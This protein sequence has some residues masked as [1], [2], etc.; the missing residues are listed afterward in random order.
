MSEPG[1]YNAEGDPPGTTRYWDGSKWIGEPVPDPTG[2][3]RLPSGVQLA[4]AGTRIGARAIDLFI[5]IVISVIVVFPTITQIIDGVDAIGP[6]ATDTQLEQV[7]T[8]ALDANA[9]RLLLA[10]AIGVAWDLAWVSAVGGTPGKLMLGLRVADPASGASPPGFLKAALRA[11]NR[12]V[13]FIPV[14]G[15]LLVLLIGLISLV[16]LFNDDQRRTVMDRIAT[17]VVVKK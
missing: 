3:V 8:E 1:W 17:T 2:A 6:S 4:D 9:G 7:V 15:G 14:V 12:A 10:F 13:G 16:L 11:L 5:I